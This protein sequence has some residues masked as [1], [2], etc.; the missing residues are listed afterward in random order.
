MSYRVTSISR[1]I[2]FTGLSGLGFLAILSVIF[3]GPDGTRPA[4][5]ALMS[6][7][8]AWV[9]VLG[10]RGWRCATLLASGHQVTVRGLVMTTSV[11]WQN[12]DRF[13]ANTRPARM[14]GLPIQVRRRVLGVQMRNGRTR[15]FHELSCR[16]AGDGFSWVDASVARLNAMLAVHSPPQGGSP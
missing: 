5:L 4:N 13:V 12:I 7:L 1:R 9:I 15:W 2:Y 3:S 14:I 8:L 11:Q 16:P 10:I 6:V